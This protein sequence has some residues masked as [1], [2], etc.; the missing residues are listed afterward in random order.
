[1]AL[2]LLISPVTPSRALRHFNILGIVGAES[3]KDK[4]IN[5]AAS[6]D[7]I[8]RLVTLLLFAI[9]ASL[10][11]TFWFYRSKPNNHY[12]QLGG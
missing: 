9:L 2:Y 8:C 7:P 4:L 11:R 5:S 3:F 12:L 6:A 1:M 10:P